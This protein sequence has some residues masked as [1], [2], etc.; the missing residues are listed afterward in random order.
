MKDVICF[1]TLKAKL[2]RA[3]SPFDPIFSASLRRM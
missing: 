3:L 2:A 1:M